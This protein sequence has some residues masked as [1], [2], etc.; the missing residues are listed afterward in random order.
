MQ[1]KTPVML[2]FPHYS[3]SLMTCWALLSDDYVILTKHPTHTDN[4]LISTTIPII[5]G[6]V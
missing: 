6:T 1:F 5:G 2:N 3:I 4:D